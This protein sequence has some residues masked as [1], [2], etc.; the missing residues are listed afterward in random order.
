MSSRIVVV[1]A[2]G[3]AVF[4]VPPWSVQTVVQ[5]GGEAFVTPDDSVVTTADSCPSK[6]AVEGSSSFARY[7]REVQPNAEEALPARVGSD[8][9]KPKRRNGHGPF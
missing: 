3:K 5:T 2:V 7:E 1:M 6:L 4:S 8:G 9:H